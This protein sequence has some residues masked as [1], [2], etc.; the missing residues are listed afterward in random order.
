LVLLAV[1]V[2][3]GFLGAVRPELSCPRDVFWISNLGWLVPPAIAPKTAWLQV[4]GRVVQLVF[5]QMVATYALDST[6][7]E[8]FA[9]PEAW[10]VTG[11][12]F[13]VK[14]GSVLKHLTPLIS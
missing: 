1:I 7:T 2:T 4:T 5:V 9:A 11:P 14:N 10:M 8:D 3:S 12:Q 6:P 13:F